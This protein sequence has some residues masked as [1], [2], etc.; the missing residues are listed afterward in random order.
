MKPLATMR[1][2][3]VTGAIISKRDL[4]RFVIDPERNLIADIDE[5]LPGRG[6]WVKA[7][8][9]TIVR[10]I[11]KKIFVKNIKEKIMIDKNLLW[12]IESL[13]KIKSYNRYHYPVRLAR[14]CLALTK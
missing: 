12:R 11:Q 9:Q 2:C 7:D 4:I 5:N 13:V 10:A 8:R 1:K 6:Y 3:L 14:L